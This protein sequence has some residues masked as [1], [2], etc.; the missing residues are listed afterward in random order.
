MLSQFNDFQSFTDNR[1]KN[2]V[3]SVKYLGW[4]LMRNGNGRCISIASFKSY[5]IDCQ[6]STGSLMAYLNGLVLPHL[7]NADVV[8]C[9][10]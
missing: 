2:R 5:G 9:H 3:P 1:E 7:D 8:C 4:Y 6:C 10:R